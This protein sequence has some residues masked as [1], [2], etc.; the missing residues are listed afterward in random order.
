MERQKEAGV[1][2]TGSSHQSVDGPGPEHWASALAAGVRR[3]PLIARNTS[4]DAG[5]SVHPGDSAMRSTNPEP[6]AWLSLDEHARR[7][8][9]HELM[10]SRRGYKQP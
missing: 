4:P 10:P 3:W 7:S 9:A 6:T 1:A 2:L 5:S 8:T